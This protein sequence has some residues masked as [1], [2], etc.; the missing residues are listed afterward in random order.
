MLAMSDLRRAGI[1]GQPMGTVFDLTADPNRYHEKIEWKA[2]LFRRSHYEC[3][4][5]VVQT[6]KPPLPV[7]RLTIPIV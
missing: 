3:A 5:S 6:P 1:F 7:L 4:L 2:V